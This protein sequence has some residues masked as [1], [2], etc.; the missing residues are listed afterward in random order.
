MIK[1]TAGL[2]AVLF[3]CPSRYNY[4]IYLECL[5]VKL[6]IPCEKGNNSVFF[7]TWMAFLKNKLVIFVLREKKFLN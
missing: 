1:V 3:I 6:F 5:N 4:D 7:F 2:M